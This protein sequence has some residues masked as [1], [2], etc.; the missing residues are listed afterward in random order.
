[1]RNKKEIRYSLQLLIQ[2]QK[3]S[4]YKRDSGYALLVTSVLAILMFSMLSTYLFSS[5]LFKSSGNAMI[6]ATSTFYS[7]ETALNKRANYIRKKFDSYSNPTGT[8]PSGA[9]IAEQM[10]VCISTTAIGSK[11]T[12]DFNCRVDESDYKEAFTTT[13][14]SANGSFGGASGYGKNGNIKYKSFSFVKALPNPGGGPVEL[15]VIDVG[16][17]RGLRSLDYRYRVY[18]TAIKEA[19][20]TGTNISAQSMLQME[21]INRLIPVFQFAA[22]YENDLE[23]TSST[24]MVVNGP[25]HTNKS[26]Y[27]S[28]GGLLTLNNP[29]TYAK[30]IFRSRPYVANHSGTTIGKRV[31]LAGGGPYTDSP[32]DCSLG[33]K[34]CIEVKNAWS[35]APTAISQVDINASNGM[36]KKQSKLQ[37]PP[38]GFLGRSG[39][40][41][42]K[43]DLRIDFNPGRTGVGTPFNVT[44]INRSLITP[45]LEDFSTKPGLI[46]SLQKP[47][48]LRVTNDAT[49]QLS[50]VT[51]LCPR[52]GGGLGEPTGYA[53]AIPA[54]TTTN[55]PTLSRTALLT[56]NSKNNAISALLEAIART[57]G[58]TYEATK[59]PAAGSL[60]TAFENALSTFGIT[61]ATRD[62]I[63]SL[64]L[65]VIAALNTTTTDTSTITNPGKGGC[66]LPAPMQVL[67][68]QTDRKENRSMTILQSNIKS[69]VVWNRDGWYWDTTMKNTQDKL[70][71][72]K[73]TAR[74]AAGL[75]APTIDA[76]QNAKAVVGA[77]C[78]Y[79]CLELSPTDVSEGGL[80]WHY[81]MIDR[82]SPYNYLSGDGITR[83]DSKGLS[84]YGFAFSGGNRLPG[85]LTIASD[86][87]VYLQGD[88][89]NPSNTAGDTSATLDGSQFDLRNA[90]NYPPAT[91]KKPASVLTDS[92]T[93]LSNKCYDVNNYRL[94]C[95]NT[96]MPNA[97]DTSVTSTVVRAAILSG[98]ENFKIDGNGNMVENGPGLNNHIRMLESWT[99]VTFK[100]KGS[101]VSQ[102]I[103]TEFNG[104][105]LPGGTY[106]QIPIR[107]FGFDTDFNR[108]DGLPPL[109]PRVSLLNQQVFKRDYD[110]QDR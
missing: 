9:N 81:S 1:M 49:R 21:F 25:V 64:P 42:D 19:G 52:L 26:L 98:T 91:E 8:E 24:D 12:G 99:G 66:F 83:V 85:A 59:L 79:D 45:T 97:G 58:V 11:G 80:V 94:N 63:T 6:D 57:P 18:S 106:Y 88:Y 72:T 108:A 2:L 89:N 74:I 77:N 29:S 13:T 96:V 34:R 23:I 30:N 70:F 76:A 107:D 78:D 102:G 38:I 61:G 48:L 41:Y 17:F 92:I 71:M 86:Q 55:F 4:S 39:D 43:A 104:Q 87:A 109:T 110:S 105:Y 100:Y 37:L 14:K 68:G 53:D 103:P 31:L 56:V 35:S 22:F 36:L 32:A 15:K 16:D 10:A 67:T 3:M 7:A 101:F 69:L 82:N 40:Y 44:S 62:S 51:R 84:P 95:F 47:V 27:L 60:K 65:N 28:P 73:R 50:E 5:R 46:N 93:I 33:T 90:A 54:F 20:S 75:P